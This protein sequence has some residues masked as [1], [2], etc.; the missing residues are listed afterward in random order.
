MAESFDM[1]LYPKCKN[2]YARFFRSWA[3]KDITNLIVANR[4]HPSIVMWSIGNEIPEQGSEEGRLISTRLQGLCHALDPTR[5]VTQGLDHAEASIESG[6]AKAMDVPG[7]NYRVH[8]YGKS[9]KQLHQGFLLGSAPNTPHGRPLTIPKPS[10]TPTDS[11]RV[12]MLSIVLGA[13]CPTTTGFGKMT[14]TG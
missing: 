13:T 8:K 14:R 12:T 6:V 5:P 2:G 11:V 7:F 10:L 1:W 4:N 3:E 9:I